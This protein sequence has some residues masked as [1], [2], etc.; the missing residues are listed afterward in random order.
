MIM[1]SVSGLVS[2]LLIHEL[3]H[4]VVY[5]ESEGVDRPMVDLSYRVN[6]PIRIRMH[7]LT[8]VKCLLRTWQQVMN[9]YVGQVKV[10]MT[11]HDRSRLTL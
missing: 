2:L 8:N 10:R 7:N 3:M 1:G 5:Q 6:E 4:L 9:I 11:L